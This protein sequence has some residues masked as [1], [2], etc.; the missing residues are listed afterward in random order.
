MRLF[1]AVFP[2]PEVQRTALAL[3]DALRASGGSV[4]WV[5]LDNLHFTLR[6]MGEL[7]ESGMRRAAE[8]GEEAVRG[9]AAFDAELGPLGAFPNPR[10][11]R[12]LWVSMREGAESLKQIAAALEQA[13]RAVASSAPTSRSRRTSRWG[14]CARSIATGPIRWRVPRSRPAPRRASASIGW[15]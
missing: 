7:G 12:V 9:R 2:P 8:A 14:A 15:C 4:S 6:F 3:E 1:F 5:K 10:R 13:L 11:A